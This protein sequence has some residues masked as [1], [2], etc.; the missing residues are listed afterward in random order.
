MTLMG[1]ATSL[2][3]A[4][5]RA[6]ARIATLAVFGVLVVA[7]PALASP[8]S[9]PAPTSTPTT[10]TSMPSGSTPA[11]TTPAGS[12]PTT[13][14]GQALPTTTT[15]IRSVPLEAADATYLASVSRRVRAADTALY[16]AQRDNATAATRAAHEAD[17]LAAAQR[18]LAA[19]AA[20]EQAVLHE[21]AV[22]RDRL[23]ALAVSSYVAGGSA[24]PLNALLSAQSFEDFTH[25]QELVNSMADTASRSL[26][27]YEA[28]R[29][30]ASSASRAALAAVDVATGSKAKADG[31]ARDAAAALV[32]RTNDLTDLVQLLQL[33][34]AA[35]QYP[36]TDIPLLFL[37]AYRRAAAAVQA[38]G[39]QLPWSALA[40]IGKIESDH[41]RTHHTALTINGDLIPPIIGPRLD[42]TNGTALIAD[43]DQGRWDG[44]PVFDHAV[45]PLQIIPSTWA[46]IARDGNGDGAADPNNIY[47]AALGAA[48]Y[49]CRASPTISAGDDQALS[50]AFFSYNHADFYVTEALALTH[51]YATVTVSP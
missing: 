44:D 13:V 46:R 24:G 49:L 14:A 21:M 35:V 3:G 18:Q 7:Q 40:A 26:R 30:K 22:T 33:A 43:T 1:P 50:Q 12:P 25:R 41:G 51:L 9:D 6:R 11:G 17:L 32:R 36:G 23:R 2:F 20:R 10:S 47:D 37:D 16:A 38:T 4:A 27:K 29:D 19:V 5:T 48:V 42:G 31:A 45:G 28:A 34:T 8:A 39:C 15:T